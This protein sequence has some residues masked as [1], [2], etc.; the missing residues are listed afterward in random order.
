MQKLSKLAAEKSGTLGPRLSRMAAP[1]YC[2]ERLHEK[3]ANGCQDGCMEVLS[4]VAAQDAVIKAERGKVGTADKRLYRMAVRKAVKDG[5]T[6]GLGGR[7]QK[8]CNKR[9]GARL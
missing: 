9:L 8:S 3:I 7:L 4:N 5:C 1:E 6:K 2:T